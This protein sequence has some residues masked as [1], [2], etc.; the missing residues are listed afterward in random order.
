MFVD[1]FV[2]EKI[3][4]L[5]EILEI[6]LN[7]LYWCAFWYLSWAVVT[8]LFCLLFQKRRSFTFSLSFGFSSKMSFS[9]QSNL[10]VFLVLLVVLPSLL[11]QKYPLAPTKKDIFFSESNFAGVDLSPLLHILSV[12][13][14]FAPLNLSC[15][16][17]RRV[18]CVTFLD[19]HL[20]AFVW[21]L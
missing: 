3:S 5:N 1:F 15:R 21:G 16:K 11:T 7:T 8:F 18:S 17:S 19:P 14:T 20:M 10:L 12:R 9:V 13:T 4:N 6:F 2:C